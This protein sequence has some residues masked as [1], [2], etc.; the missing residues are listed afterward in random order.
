[1]NQCEGQ[2]SL[3]NSVPKEEIF[4]C[5]TC[6]Y[7]IQGCCD[8]PCTS[9]DYCVL[10]DKKNPP[11]ARVRAWRLGGKRCPGRKADV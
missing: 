2:I 1:M 10:G 9:D 8:Y 4:P 5:D 7:Q 11:K 3:F 6:G